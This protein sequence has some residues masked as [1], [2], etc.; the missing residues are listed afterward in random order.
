MKMTMEMTVEEHF[1]PVLIFSIT[2]V[3]ELSFICVPKKVNCI[4]YIQFFL[5]PFRSRH[6]K[7]EKGIK[8]GGIK[9]SF[10]HYIAGL[11]SFDE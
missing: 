6:N 3:K 4:M 1:T 8:K 11:N 2:A 9:I 10:M 7:R 5:V